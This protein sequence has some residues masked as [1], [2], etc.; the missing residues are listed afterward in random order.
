MVISSWGMLSESSLLVLLLLR[1]EISELGLEVALAL[2]KSL[3]FSYVCCSSF[4]P[5]RTPATPPVVSGDVFCKKAVLEKKHCQQTA[6]NKQLRFMLRSLRPGLQGILQ[7]VIHLPKSFLRHVHSS[8]G[9]SH[10]ILHLFALR[11]GEELSVL[12]N[13]CTQLREGTEEACLDK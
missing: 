10:C 3:C 2:T 9:R 4:R 1:L 6:K 13:H 8:S 5:E 11:L 12:G 7:E